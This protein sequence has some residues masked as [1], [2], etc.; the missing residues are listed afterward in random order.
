[1]KFIKYLRWGGSFKTLGTPGLEE[2]LLAS[3]RDQ[4]LVVHSVVR[5]YTD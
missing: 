4:T 2:K 5:H 1:M 3:A